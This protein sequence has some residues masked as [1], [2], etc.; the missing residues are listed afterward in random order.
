MRVLRVNIPNNSYDI[1]IE[2]GLR[3]SFAKEITE[4][5]SGDKIFIITDLNVYKLYGE[6]FDKSLRAEGI[7]PFFTVV[8][9][10]EKSKSMEILIKVYDDLLSNEINRGH[11][12]VALG[13]GVVGDLT[14]FVAATLLRGI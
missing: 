1:K 6:D 4:I 7:E 12:I 10:G 13:G 8:E 9:P 14:G 5:Y 2:K 3:K 11:M